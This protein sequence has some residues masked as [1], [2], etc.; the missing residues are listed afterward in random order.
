[1]ATY[2]CRVDLGTP[3]RL[4]TCLAPC[5]LILATYRCRVDLGTPR[6]LATCLAPCVLILATYRC[7]VDLGTPR[8]LATCFAPSPF[9]T[10]L[11]VSLIWDGCGSSSCAVYRTTFANLFCKYMTFADLVSSL[12]FDACTLKYQQCFTYPLTAFM[13]ISAIPRDPFRLTSLHHD[14]RV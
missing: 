10:Q 13:Q 4:A 11:T 12:S 6:R 8:R 14:E 9:K 5:V 1:M 2:R 7:R 3:R